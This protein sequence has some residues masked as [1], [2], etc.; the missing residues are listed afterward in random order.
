[1]LR[2]ACKGCRTAGRSA[3]PRDL[4]KLCVDEEPEIPTAAVASMVD[5]EAATWGGL[6]DASR[7]APTKREELDQRSL[8]RG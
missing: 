2:S 1:M 5:I 8:T 4:E 3:R 7:N 6:A